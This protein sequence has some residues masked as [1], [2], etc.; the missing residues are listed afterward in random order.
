MLRPFEQRFPFNLDWNLLRTFMVVVERKGVSRAADFLGLKQPTI[1]SALKRLEDAAGHKLIERS[2]ARFQVTRAGKILYEE[3]LSVFGTV[4]RLPSLMAA[5]DEELAGHISIVS[6]SHVVSP[7]LDA[8]LGRFAATHPGV[9][10]SIVVSESAEVLGR[11]RQNQA[12]LGICLLSEPVKTLDCRILFREN[13]G[14][15]C[16][17]RHRLFGRNGIALSELRGEPS[18][19][20]QTEIEHGPLDSVTRLRARAGLTPGLKGVSPNLT[21]VRRMITA[22]IGIGAL[23]VHVASQDVAHGLLWQLPPYSRLPEVDIFLVTNPK[24]T[25]SP[26]ETVFIRMI[27]EMIDTVPLEERTYS[28]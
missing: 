11:V 1:S 24:R 3:C 17:Q 9:T 16:G 19:S 21:E 15:Y 4:S 7:H 2:P 12:S 6:A 10:Y 18:V 14:L 25:L 13:F 5:E 8:V 28:G 20:F 23:P 26:P 27:D 22:G